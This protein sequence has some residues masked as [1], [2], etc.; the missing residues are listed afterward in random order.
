MVGRKRKTEVEIS[1]EEQVR[2][3]EHGG[4]CLRVRVRKWGKEEAANDGMVVLY[5][6]RILVRVR[7]KVRADETVC[8][9]KHANRDHA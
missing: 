4:G 5:T 3:R 6:I 9:G 7:G 8:G 1:E 2:R